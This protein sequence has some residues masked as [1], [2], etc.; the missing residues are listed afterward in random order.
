MEKKKMVSITGAMCSTLVRER[1]SLNTFLPRVFKVK[2]AALSCF[3]IKEIRALGE[4]DK[5][6]MNGFPLNTCSIYQYLKNIGH[7]SWTVPQN[8]INNEECWAHWLLGAGELSQNMLQTRSFSLPSAF[9]KHLVLPEQLWEVGR[10]KTQTNK[11]NNTQHK[12]N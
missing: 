9:S 6:Q 11:K 3:T 10:K 12:T 7:N 8:K 2:I 1:E 5:G 4:K